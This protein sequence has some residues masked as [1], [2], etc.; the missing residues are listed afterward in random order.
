MNVY[1]AGTGIDITNNVVSTTNPCGLSI[2]QTY[3]GGIIF[4]LDASG[5]H[6]L[7]AAPSDQSTGIQWYNGTYRITGTTGDGLGAGE[8]NTAMIVATQMADNQSGNF[9]AKVCADYSVTVGG[10]TYGDWYLPSKYELNLIYI[11]KL[12]IGGFASG[13]YWSSTDVSNIDAW[14]QD[15]LNGLQSTNLKNFT[16]YVRAIRAF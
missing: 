11:N 9:A 7:I 4:Y 16:Y 2:G 1:T 15:F 3:Q 8:M 5:C 6:G 14:Y 13:F 12:T 10:V